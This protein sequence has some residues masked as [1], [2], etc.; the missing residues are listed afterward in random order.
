MILNIMREIF[1][2]YRFTGENPNDLEKILG[3]IQSKLQ[4]SGHKVFCSYFLEEYFKEQRMTSKDIY[5]YCLERQADC[6]TFI[7]LVKSKDISNGMELESTRAIE[8]KQNYILLIKPDLAFPHFR[9]A[10]NQ[11]LEYN[12]FFQLYQRLEKLIWKTIL[13]FSFWILLNLSFLHLFVK[14]G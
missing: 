7:A 10:A 11:I 14:F 13:N 12:S 2:S 1:L 5:S 8:L 6:N 3:N 9:S 4:N